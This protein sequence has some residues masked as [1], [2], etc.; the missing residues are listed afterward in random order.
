MTDRIIE[1]AETAAFLSLDNRRL[2]I[3]LPERDELFIP[4]AEIQCLILANPAVTVTGA[5]LSGLAEAG[6]TVVVSG[7]KAAEIEKKPEQLLLF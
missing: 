2:K 6:A 1:I 7:K 4:L 5:L 3:D